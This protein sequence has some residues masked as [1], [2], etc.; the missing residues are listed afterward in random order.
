M[1][2]VTDVF[3]AGSEPSQ[4]LLEQW[5][6]ESI[7]P[8]PLYYSE[9]KASGL[10]S[11]IGVSVEYDYTPYIP[12]ADNAIDNI[13]TDINMT[14]SVDKVFVGISIMLVV[15][16][17]IGLATK[18]KIAI[19]LIDLTLYLLFTFLG[20]FSLWIIILLA[21]VL[22]IFGILNLKGGGAGA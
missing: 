21:I 20:F 1:L 13:L 15:T 19:L 16:L 2:D 6:F 17:V 12:D 3:G 8:Y 18:S 4:A 5:Y 22:F 9:Y 11:T 7:D 14:S 10:L